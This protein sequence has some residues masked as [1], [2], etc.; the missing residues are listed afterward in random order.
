MALR[1]LHRAADARDVHDTRR[2]PLA[3]LAALREEPEE[4]SG[5]EED[6]G[7]VDGVDLRPLVE[8]FILEQRAAKGLRRFMLRQG[9]VVEETRDGPD[10]SCAGSDGVS[11]RVA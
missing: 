7:R 9:R 1:E 10:L 2:V 3:V 8:R 6:R 5:H 4:R 11:C